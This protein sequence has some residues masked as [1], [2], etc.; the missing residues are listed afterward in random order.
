MKEKATQQ[1]D[2][3]IWLQQ[4]QRKAVR[5]LLGFIMVA[6]LAGVLWSVLRSIL[7]KG[8]LFNLAYY[9]AAYTLVLFVY[10][11][12]P[13]SDKWR[14]VGFAAVLYGFGVFSLYSGW[15]AGGGRVFLLAFIVVTAVLLNPRSGIYAAGLSL[16][17]FI[18]FGVGFNQGWITL[19]KLPDPA[20]TTPIITEGV[21]FALAIGMVVMGLWFFGKALQAADKSTY[22]LQASRA[23]FHNIVE[24]NTDG[25]VVADQAGV[26]RFANG[27]AEAMLGN[28]RGPLAGQK[29]KFPLQ[30]GA[31][32]ELPLANPA[33]GRV[34]E[35]H[36]NDTE[37]EDQPAYL[38]IFRDISI[39]K[40]AERALQSSEA[41]MRALLHAI[42]DLIFEFDSQGRYLDVVPAKESDPIL[43]KE[44]LIGKNISQVLP[45]QVSQKARRAIK[46]ALKTGK[47]QNLEYK[48]LM[49]NGIRDYE[50]RIVAIGEDR[51]LSIV[52]D[53][54]EKKSFENQLALS[55]K[56][57]RDFV[58]RSSEGIWLLEFDEPIPVDLPA[59]EQV[60][61]L[62]KSGYLSECNHSLAKMYGYGQRE[63]ILGMRLLELYGTEENA[64]KNFPTT[65]ELVKSG[66]R[67]EH[68][69][70]VEMDKNGRPVYFMNNAVGV[71]QED[72]LT[73]VWGI[74]RDVTALKQAEIER[75]AL[76]EELSAKNAELERFT[77]TV[78]HDLKSPLVTIRGFAGYLEQDARTGN[79][80]RLQGDVERISKAAE[81]MQRLLGELL[82]LSR[83]GRLTNPP[84]A[85]PFEEIVQE[86][87]SLVEGPLAEVHA[88]V[89]VQAGMPVVFGDRLRLVEV[90]QNL[91]DNAVKFMG[92]QEK[93]HIEIGACRLASGE[94]AFF[95][96]DNGI[97]IPPR[98]QDRVFRLF[99]KLDLTSP[100]TGVGL[101]I[102]KRIVDFH[103]G[104]I[105]VESDGQGN[106]STFYFT[107]PIN[108]A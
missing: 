56:K 37:W 102:V 101:A 4:Q 57:Y 55:E 52:R 61:R 70:T 83:I 44:Q 40:Q 43:P 90:V 106:G 18:L 81:K 13:V 88:G 60:M 30:A 77:Y 51:V 68:R 14:A 103:N 41:R 85:V 87:L 94:Q 73:G 38:A 32:L 34:V 53:I 48:L 2:W 1:R 39:R 58:E 20:S 36:V 22:E 98:Y 104:K 19:M 9:I 31:C 15:L 29:A 16:L 45:A 79:V 35:L 5:R 25:V 75:E 28:E 6:G 92:A 99:D 42:P 54:T 100:G 64:R 82:E 71:I 78:S 72:H 8:S 65:L 86:A 21:G 74:Q 59:E 95:V 46:Q 23:S 76:I 66:Y 107:L 93:P 105:W 67:R 62:Q 108:Q 89:H 49:P 50:A 26:V 69:E 96:K 10:Y 84:T 63:E 80:E 7:E 33:D 17:T 47:T 97:G 12:G 11:L 27:A 3:T 91:L 24:R